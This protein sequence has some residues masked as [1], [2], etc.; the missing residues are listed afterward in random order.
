MTPVLAQGT[1]LRRRREQSCAGVKKR[2]EWEDDKKP[3]GQRIE[4][5][6]A[7]DLGISSEFPKEERVLGGRGDVV[8]KKQ[9]P[10]RR[11]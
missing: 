7:W 10:T 9:R 8:G 4:H 11:Y 2:K 6:A 3:K 1:L 5:H